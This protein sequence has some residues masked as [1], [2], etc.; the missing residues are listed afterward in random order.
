MDGLR[1][2]DFSRRLVADGG[3]RRSVLR[4]LAGSTL[5]AALTA[6]GLG[7]LA[8]ACR[9]MGKQC[10]KSSQCCAGKCKNHKCKCVAPA[11]KQCGTKSCV[12]PNQCCN[13]AECGSGPA[14]LRRQVH[15]GRRLLHHPDCG[16]PSLK[17]CDGNC[18]LQSDCC[19][20]HRLPRR[21]E[22]LQRRLQGVLRP[23][24]LRRRAT[25]LRWY[26]K[27][28][29]DGH[30]ETAPRTASA[31]AKGTASAT[32]NVAP[33]SRMR[34]RQALLQ[35]DCI[36]ETNCCVDT[37]ARKA[38]AKSAATPQRQ[39]LQRVLRRLAIA[40][41][42][43][44]PLQQRRSAANARPAATTRMHRSQILKCCGGT[45]RECCL[46]SDC[47][48]TEVCCPPG[49]CD[50]CC[51][52]S[53]NPCPEEDP[54]S[55]VRPAL[56]GREHLHKDLANTCDDDADC[57]STTTFRG[58]RQQGR[59]QGLLLPGRRTCCQYSAG[60]GSAA[61]NSVCS[62]MLHRNGTVAHH[63]IGECRAARGW[64]FGHG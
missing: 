44:G 35:P 55:R 3:S 64:P 6:V 54:D 38:S 47:Q 58:L 62:D 61:W 51:C 20:R 1:F 37:T 4:G 39:D 52:P 60:P 14:L 56:S 32:I 50:E 53:P 46:D 17:C 27:E 19:D 57:C 45:C 33:T 41:P 12:E 30:D 15:R 13:D 59:R 28:C 22:V 23:G 16:D 43:P 7:D 36:N 63:L 40:P 10:D 34:R 8:A 48:G 31:A 49:T 11:S 29:C 9:A 5:G 42:R 24:R 21:P 26:C 18:I 2:D 25:M